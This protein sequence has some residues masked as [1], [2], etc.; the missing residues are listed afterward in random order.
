MISNKTMMKALMKELVV[1]I[2][3]I[4]KLLRLN[5]QYF[6]FKKT[7]QK[8]FLNSNYLKFPNFS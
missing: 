1:Y 7:K 6:L 5:G 8:N 4:L 3:M 2:N